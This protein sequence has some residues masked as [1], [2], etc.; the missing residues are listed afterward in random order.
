MTLSPLLM[1]LLTLLVVP[2]CDKTM[3]AGAVTDNL[4]NSWLALGDSY[5]I[6]ES[7]KMNERFPSHTAVA[8]QQ[9]GIAVSDIK[10]LAQT[11]W[12][13]ND[14][15][16][17]IRGSALLGKYDIVSLLIGVN[18]QYQ[19]LDT[20]GYRARFTQLL[21]KSIELAGGEVKHVFVLSIP[22]YG[23]TPFGGG[24][25]TVSKQIDWFNSINKQVSTAFK[26]N[27]TDITAISREAATDPALTAG[28]GLHP[29]GKQY[30][31][32]ANLLEA[33]IRSSIR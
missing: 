7:V 23:V 18:D 13:T 15:Q 29:S 26:V 28:D 17:A 14:L 32:W 6:G 33:S 1:Y 31:R 24:S 11:G 25:A 8:L 4:A 21:Q 16:D 30:Q 22:D 9:K 20:A 3:P 19:G 10:Y 5:T 2:G 12:T 27:Y